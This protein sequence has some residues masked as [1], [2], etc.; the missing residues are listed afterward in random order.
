[1][2]VERGG[3]MGASLGLPPLGE[4]GGKLPHTPSTLAPAGKGSRGKARPRASRCEGAEEVGGGILSTRKRGGSR[5]WVG[6]LQGAGRGGAVSTC[7]AY[8]AGL[9][10]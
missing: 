9:Q 5:R 3:L 1:M 7:L 10:W 4:E 2:C 6:S 8:Y